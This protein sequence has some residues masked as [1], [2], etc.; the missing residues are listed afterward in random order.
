MQ[1]HVHKRCISS[2]DW[3]QCAAS[4]APTL[5]KRDFKEKDV[6]SNLCVEEPCAAAYLCWTE[7]YLKVRVVLCCL[8]KLAL[9]GGDQ[10]AQVLL[11]A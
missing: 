4:D 7:I 1:A 8:G 5:T 3:L 9:P 6:R 11:D 10:V 2:E